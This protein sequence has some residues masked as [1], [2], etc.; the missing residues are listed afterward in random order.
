MTLLNN[1]SH[2]ITDAG[3]VCTLL[4]NGKGY[5]SIPRL[6]AETYRLLYGWWV[7]Y[8]GIYWYLEKINVVLVLV[9]KI[10]LAC[11]RILKKCDVL[12]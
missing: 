1:W 10:K 3:S 5:G 4:S 2:D 8:I 6:T 11:P 9:Y 7:T 12:C